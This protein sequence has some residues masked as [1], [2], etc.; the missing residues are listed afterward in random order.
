MSISYQVL[1]EPGSDNAVMAT[2]NTGQ[3]QHRLLFDC[4]EGCL[5]D[6]P[7]ADIQSIEVVFFSHFHIDHVAG[8]DGFFRLNWFRP[9]VPVRIFGPKGARRIIHHRTQG[10]TW[11]LVE[12]ASGQVRVTELVDDRAWTSQYLA[13][14]GFATEHP[15]DERPFDGIAYRGRTFR[16]EAR[17]MYHGIASLAYLIREE[18]H[19][20]V[21]MEALAASGFSPGPWL[22]Q[23]K[24]KSVGSDVEIE[25]AGSTHR[26]GDLRDSLLV[27]HP[28][29]SLA[30]L[31]DFC[32]DSPQAEDELVKFLHGCRT[33]I[34]ENNFRDSDIELARNSQHMVSAD[35][36]RLAARVQP[37]ELVLF[38]VSDRYGEEEWREQLTEVRRQFDRAIFPKQWRLSNRDEGLRNQGSD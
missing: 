3:S 12:G 36:G 9:D 16:V 38:H 22:K 2:V 19:A 37:E 27:Y 15:L 1:G 6:V 33:V 13:S 32:L 23:V 5:R 24:D 18:E 35:V 7:R 20:N 30:Y 17:A 25:V 29:D 14:E 8:F 11:N 31:T 4:G 34:C 28:G 21:D 26:I 10:I